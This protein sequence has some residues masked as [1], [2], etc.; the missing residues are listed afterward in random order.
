MAKKGDSSVQPEFLSL[1]SGNDKDSDI[2][3]LQ[4][5]VT[6]LSRKNRLLSGESTVTCTPW[7]TREY[8]Y[9]PPGLHQEINDFYD[10]MKPRPSEIRMRADVISRV[11][12]VIH[13][14]WPLAKVEPFGSFVTELYLPTSDID[15]VVFG[16]WPVIPLFTLEEALLKHD[17][18]VEGTILTLDKTTVPIVKFLDRKTEVAVDIGFNHE[19]EGNAAEII[20]TYIHTYPFLPKLMLVLKQFLTQRNLNEVFYGGISSYSLVLL[21]VSFLQ[22]HP[23]HAATDPN[24][25]NLGV[26]LIE[27][28][29]LYGRH[30]NY[31]KTGILVEGGGA[32]ITKDIFTQD[33][34][35]IKD[36]SNTRLDCS[37]PMSNAAR[38][39]FGMFQVRQAFEYAFLRLNSSMLS[40]GN[41]VPR[42]ETLLGSIVRVAKEVDDYRNWIDRNYP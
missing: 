18:A 33:F 2:A 24:T 25:T 27:F 16:R 4:P 3:S 1:S 22:L 5:A 34:L 28:F 14:L 38:G 10:Y 7:R 40:S 13:S 36:P 26:L 19:S 31:M 37:D 21:L 9:D 41:P 20:Q 6:S 12:A 30:F 17:V 8:S 42:R 29:E 15:L 39:C 23:R 32:Y 11:K 35:Y